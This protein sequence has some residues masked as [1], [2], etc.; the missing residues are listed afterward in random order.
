M[1]CL[2]FYFLV[3]IIKQAAV[4]KFAEGDFQAVA[5]LFDCDDTRVLTFFVQE[6]VYRR[7]RYARNVRQSINGEVVFFA[8]LDNSCRDRFFCVHKCSPFLLSNIILQK[9]AIYRVGYIAIF[10]FL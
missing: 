7:G 10:A 2:L 5:K 8:K 4:E 6:A 9:I 1:F 3:D